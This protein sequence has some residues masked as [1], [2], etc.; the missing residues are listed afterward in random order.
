MSLN[1]FNRKKQKEPTIKD[2][3]IVD[4]NLNDVRKAI[5]K[6]TDQLPK[7][8]YRT[9]L[10]KDDYSIDF[11]QLVN[12]LGGIPSKKFYMSK[13]TYDLFDESEKY[14]PKIMDKVQKAVDHYVEDHKKYPIL[15][16]DPSRRV[17]YYELMQNH[18]L[19]FLPEIE[20]YITDYDGIITHI[21]PN[22]TK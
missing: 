2:Y 17:N 11:S 5:R 16:F 20:F 10:V 3:P 14:I 7:G 21:K 6:F 12:Y 8:T 9:I 15:E 1:F 19:D 13:E 4:V 18:Y 22:K